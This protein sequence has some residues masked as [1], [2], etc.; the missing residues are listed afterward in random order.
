MIKLFFIVW[1]KEGGGWWEL[2][3]FEGEFVCIFILKKIM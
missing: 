3:D 1:F 2:F